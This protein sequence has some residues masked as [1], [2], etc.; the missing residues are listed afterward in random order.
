[1]TA[2]WEESTANTITNGDMHPPDGGNFAVYGGQPYFLDWGWTYYGPFYLDLPN[3][4]T[5]QTVQYYRQ[6]LADRGLAIAERDFMDRYYAAGRYVGFKYLC[7]GI[8]QWPPG[9][10]EETGRMLLH[11]LQRALTGV[12]PESA[13]AY[14]AAT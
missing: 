9:P 7:A 13:F 5:A 6:A 1:M 14:S 4:F 12:F 3:H 8:W 2:L 10:T 11:M